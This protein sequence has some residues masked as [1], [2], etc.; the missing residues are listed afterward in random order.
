MCDHLYK[1]NLLSDQQWGFRSGRSTVTALLSTI[2][3]WHSELDA[4]RDICAVFFYYRKAF[5]SVP[6]LP[7]IEKL[8][9]FNLD[10]VIIVWINNY[11]FG[12]SQNVVVEGETS[13]RCLYYQEFHKVW[14]WA[15]FCS[16]SM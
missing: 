16:A 7:L 2:S 13:G 4:E 11:L 9:A 8:E 6:H 14:F 12:R 5:N 10:P 3:A 1:H 15:L